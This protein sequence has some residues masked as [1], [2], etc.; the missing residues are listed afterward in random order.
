MSLSRRVFPQATGVT[1]DTTSMTTR[2]KDELF[3]I[4]SNSRR[5]H[6]IY[7]LSEEGTELSLKELATKIAA[8]EADVPEST[9][10]SEER[11]RVYISL[12]QTHLPKLEEANIVTY[13]EDDRTVVLTD[14]LL[15]SGFFWMDDVEESE[16][17]PW[18]RYYLALSVASWVLIGGVWLSLPFVSLLGWSGVALVVSA[19]LL[20]LVVAQYA[21]ARSSVA[22]EN[23]GYELL[24]E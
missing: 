7:Y 9:I 17:R 19:A 18:F 14:E 1:R 10:T 12:Y 24:I 22:E 3:Q 21:D 13:D 23:A 16:P 15:D 11:Q 4:L 8:V 2:S 20:M 6:I 5:R